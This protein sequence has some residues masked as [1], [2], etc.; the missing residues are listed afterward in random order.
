M[1]DL[2]PKQSEVLGFIRSMVHEHGRPPTT[3]EI[4]L[5]LNIKHVS[6]AQGHLFSLVKKGKI[7]I[8]P[9]IARGIQLVDG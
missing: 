2:T 1:A 7:K 3:R 9:N 4:M 6:T 8:A 5:G